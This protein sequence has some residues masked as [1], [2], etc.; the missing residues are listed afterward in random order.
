LFWFAR[1]TPVDDQKAQAAL[2]FKMLLEPET[3]PTGRRQQTL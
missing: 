3:F 2:Y 1:K